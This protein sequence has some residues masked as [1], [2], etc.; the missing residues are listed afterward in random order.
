MM[1]GRGPSTP[2]SIGKLSYKPLEQDRLISQTLQ[3]IFTLLPNCR[4]DP[5][6]P[7]LSSEKSLNSTLC[8]FLDTRSRTEFPMVRFKHEAPQSGTHTSD[9]G[10]HGVGEITTVGTRGYTMYQPF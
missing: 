10:V 8:D 4:D 9:V 1:T 7:A 5:K 2:G 6:R 3:F